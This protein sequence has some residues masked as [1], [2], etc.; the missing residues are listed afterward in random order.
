MEV[1]GAVRGILVRG[2]GTACEHA[3]GWDQA[4]LLALS[5]PTQA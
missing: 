2:A 1:A 5:L 3:A 4:N